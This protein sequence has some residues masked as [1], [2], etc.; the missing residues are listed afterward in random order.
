M[1]RARRVRFVVAVLASAAA[2]AAVTAGCRQILGIEDR[3]DDALTCEAYCTTIA[4]ACTGDDLQYISTDTCMGMCATFPVGIADAGTG[5]SLAC[6]ITQ[7]NAILAGGEGSCAA[8]GPG[9]DNICG[10]NCDGFCV[11]VAAI[12][13]DDFK[14]SL[15]CQVAC[16][17]IPDAVCPAYF[18]QQDVVPNFDSI[19]CRLYHLSAATQNA[20]EHCPH[21]LGESGY[22][23]PAADGG[24]PC[25]DGGG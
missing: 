24:V 25:V 1:T 21:T 6:R 19:Q 13:P 16:A 12:C 3:G 15:G 2:V 7:A 17:Q 4:M 10:T 23:T 11:G 8:A 20:A 9:G 18:V 14:T 22:C 5:N